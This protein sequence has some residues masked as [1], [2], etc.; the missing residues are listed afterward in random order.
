MSNQVLTTQV[1]AD[2][3]AKAK[4]SPGL[5]AWVRLLRGHA[6]ARRR[7]NA[8]LHAEHGLTVNAYEA[9]LLLSKADGGVLRRVDLAE[10]L[11]LTA[12]G[13]TRLLDGLEEQ[14]CV[15]K[16]S[17]SSDA[18]VTYAAL[19]DTGRK[20]LEK[21]SSS[22]VAGIDALF[23]ERF[24]DRELETLVELLGRL[25]GAGGVTGTDCTP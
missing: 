6:A 4:G 23:E 14:K 22:H 20:K 3:A 12:S 24:T 21:A 13:V 8:Q 5:Q 9:L 15:E 17:C 25:P 7:I 16:K 11:Q 1:S 2:A 18:R 10:E 19:T